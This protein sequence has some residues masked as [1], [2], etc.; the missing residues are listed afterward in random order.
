MS[1]KIK[2]T[3]L[4]TEVKLVN[5]VVSPETPK[6]PEPVLKIEELVIEEP[7]ESVAPKHEEIVP[8]YDIGYYKAIKYFTTAEAGLLVGYGGSYDR[9]LKE[10]D[11]LSL[12]VFGE[13]K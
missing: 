5:D 3:K 13:I 9:S 7:V 12:Q 2:E 10:W 1:I 6:P 4:E 8:M 11:N